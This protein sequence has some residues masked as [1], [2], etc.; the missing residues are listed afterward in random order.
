MFALKPSNRIPKGP[1]S[2]SSRGSLP[3]LE[4]QGCFHRRGR[5]PASGE[6][7]GERIPK[8]PEKRFADAPPPQQQRLSPAGCLRSGLSH[9]TVPSGANLP[10]SAYPA[11]KTSHYSQHFSEYSRISPPFF[12]NLIL[13]SW[14]RRTL[15]VGALSFAMIFI[16]THDLLRDR[17]AALQ[18]D[19][20]LILRDH[21]DR[22][23]LR[24]R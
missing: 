21:L 7:C 16:S 5:N 20:D 2:A 15:P 3:V 19:H 18:V 10:P 23:S 9:S 1:H 24:V 12:I 22:I 17:R 4:E 11:W 14:Q 13:F 8:P 6:D